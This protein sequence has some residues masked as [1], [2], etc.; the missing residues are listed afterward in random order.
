MKVY[1]VQYNKY[2]GRWIY[3]GY[4]RA[5]SSLGYDIR[6]PLDKSA[7][8]VDIRS[9]GPSTRS[10]FEEDYIFMIADHF[11][12]KN[13]PYIMNVIENSYKTYMFAQP[14]SFPYPW[15]SHGNFVSQAT[16]EYIQ[17]INQLDN[18]FLWSW[19]DKSG[20]NYYNKWKKVETIPLIPS[21][22]NRI[23]FW[24]IKNMI[25]VLWVAGLTTGLVKRKRLW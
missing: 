8:N 9:F 24:N 1:I 15:G 14:N 5:W 7:S 6:T 19:V 16:P 20:A 4:A 2:A 18:V 10:E 22:I 17:Q 13:D 23:V 12:Y 25:L 3:E 11:L 21:D